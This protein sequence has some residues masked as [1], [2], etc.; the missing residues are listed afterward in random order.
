[1]EKPEAGKIYSL[2]G[3]PD[4]PSIMRGDSLAASEVLTELSIRE[5]AQRVARDW[6]RVNFGAV[7]YLQA[8]HDLESIDDNYFQDTG[9]SVVAYFLSNATTWRGN[10]ARAIKAELKR[11]LK[12]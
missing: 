4:T 3:G 10:V 11:R 2:T 6:K 12:G 9:D 8:M 1:M 5:L 7:P